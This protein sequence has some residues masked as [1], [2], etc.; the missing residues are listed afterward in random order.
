MIRPALIRP[1]LA[2]LRDTLDSEQLSQLEDTIALGDKGDKQFILL[3]PDEYNADGPD[4]AHLS[5]VLN[6]DVFTQ[7]QILRARCAA[8]QLRA[9]WD[10]ERAQGGELRIPHVP[11]TERPDFLASPGLNVYGSIPCQSPPLFDGD[12]FE[13]RCPWQGLRD[14]SLLGD[15]V[16]DLST[17]GCIVDGAILKGYIMMVDG[18]TKVMMPIGGGEQPCYRNRCD[19]AQ[20]ITHDHAARTRNHT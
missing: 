12:G 20:A 19:H 13:I 7:E 14:P 18:P 4:E 16:I 15:T 8:E 2:L 1:V 6:P 17:R 5:A 10:A 11:G 3:N 9:A